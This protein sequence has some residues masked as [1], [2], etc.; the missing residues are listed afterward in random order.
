[1]CG[2]GWF[3]VGAELFVELGGDKSKAA[4]LLAAVPITGARSL[5][6]QQACAKTVTFLASKCGDAS[7]AAAFAKR[8]LEVFPLS[9]SLQA[10]AKA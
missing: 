6:L 3:V 8:A 1:M 4:A 10:A 5:V 2:V 7:G 9:P